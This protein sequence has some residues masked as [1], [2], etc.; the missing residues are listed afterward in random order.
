MCRA[1]M[2]YFALFRYLFTFCVRIDD[3]DVVA[4]DD[5]CDYYHLSDRSVR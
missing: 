4:D 1:V 5:V 2:I 3:D